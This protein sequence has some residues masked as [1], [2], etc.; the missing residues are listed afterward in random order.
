MGWGRVGETDA[1]FSFGEVV[2]Q[3]GDPEPAELVS[4][5]VGPPTGRKE[6]ESVATPQQLDA[7]VPMR[8]G[9]ELPTRVWSPGETGHLVQSSTCTWM[10]CTRRYGLMDRS[11]MQLC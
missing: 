7:M 3:F 6:A 10:L 9:V 5:V 2:G 11:G 4:W 8:D 1:Y